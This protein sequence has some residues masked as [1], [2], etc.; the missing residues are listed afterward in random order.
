MEVILDQENVK[1][2]I[3]RVQRNGGAPGV[4][5]IT[6]DSLV[7]YM[8]A[9]WSRIQKELKSGTY[10]PSPV[11]RVE[12]PKPGGGYRMLGIPTVIDRVIQ[13]SFLQ[14]L[15]PAWDRTFSEYS[16]GFRPKR[17]QHNAI[18]AARALIQSGLEYV[19][20]LDL[21]KF[22][23]RVN[24]DIL[25]ARVAKRVEDKS[26]LKILRAYLNAGILENGLVQP[27]TEGVPQGGPLSPLLSN[28]LLDELDKE[29][30]KRGLHFVRYADDCNIYVRSERAGM[31]VKE[32]VTKFLAK[33]LRLRVNEEKSAVGKPSTRRFLG[34]TFG[35]SPEV[36]RLVAPESMRK[37][38]TKIRALIKRGQHYRFE[39]KIEKIGRYLRGWLQYFGRTD[40]L[41]DIQT[42]FGYARRRLRREAWENWKT[43]KRRR[44]ELARRGGKYDTACKVSSTSKGAWCLSRTPS[45]QTA[46]P[47]SYFRQLGFPSSLNGKLL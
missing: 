37:A 12:I 14:V 42:I 38:R 11:K 13:Q 2:A 26:V 31:R 46:F 34:F 16:F 43:P 21:E 18:D 8:M 6:V 32:S 33:R 24:H 5:G 28:L 45:I 41:T 22:F 39:V 44:L 15:Q 1:A 17:S 30:E 29:L 4:D 36:P 35:M 40:R 20:D 27:S 3:A 9:N 10:Q 19:V 23:D 7:P 25:M 47:N